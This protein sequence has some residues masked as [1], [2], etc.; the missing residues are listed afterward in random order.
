MKN[1]KPQFNSRDSFWDN[2]LI[3]KINYYDYF[4]RLL[5]MSMSVFEWG[6]LPSSIDVRYL[7]MS[8]FYDGKVVFFFDEELGLYQCMRTMIGGTLS[9]YN[10]PNIREAYAPNGY[11]RKLD[12]KN[13][14]LIFNNF[15]H[16]PS[17]AWCLDYA[18]RLTN[19]DRTIDVNVNAQK[20]PLLILCSERQK[21]T[22]KQLYA[23]YEGNEPVIYG[24]DKL[25]TDGIKSV[26]TSA[27][28]LCDRLFALKTDIWNEALTYIG[29]PNESENKKER[30]IVDEVKRSQGGVLASGYCKLEARRQACEQIN[31]MFG[32]DI[33]CNYRAGFDFETQRGN[34][35]E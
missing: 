7:E 4:Q 24:Y 22:M 1:K 20:T 28:Y 19:I 13:S 5:E 21:M 11:R 17:T 31:E 6:G 3:N 27:P 23:K 32:L 18:R 16:T 15:T 9:N 2:N 26:N 33:T 12:E 35:N 29:V 8:L 25:N 34:I 14:V 30:L 10:I